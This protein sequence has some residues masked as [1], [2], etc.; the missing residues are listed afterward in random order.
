MTRCTIAAWMLLALAAAPLCAAPVISGG[1]YYLEPRQTGQPLQDLTIS[2]SGGDAVAGVEFFAQI[3]DGGAVNGGSNTKPT[4]TAI[5]LIGAGKVFVGGLGSNPQSPGPL[6]RWDDVTVPSTVPA[7]GTL[8]TVTIDTI[9]AAGGSYTLRLQNV[10]SSVYSGGLN[11]NFPYSPTPTINDG[12]IVILHTM[13]RDSGASGA[14]TAD[15]WTGGTWNNTPIYPDDSA[16]TVINSACTVNLDG[17]R[18]TYNL[19]I[20]NGGQLSIAAGNALTV[21]SSVADALTLGTNGTLTLAAG[22][23]LTAPGV[24]LSGGTL[25]AS[26]AYSLALPV[27]C[28]TGGTLSTALSGDSL[29]L[30]G[31]VTAAASNTLNKTGSGAVNLTG[32]I[33]HAGNIAVA[34]GLLKYNL[35]GGKSVTIGSGATLDIASGATVE[36]AGALSGTSAGGNRV[37][38]TNSSTTSGLLVS[39]AGQV[40]G[41][42]TG[43]GKTTIAAGGGLTADSLAQSALDIAAT[44]SLNVIG[45]VTMGSGGLL[46]MASGAGLTVGGN[47][48]LGNATLA[49]SGAYT[50]A[51]PLSTAGG[52]LS[53]AAGGDSLAL[54]GLLTAGASNTLSKTGSGTVTLSGGINQAGD[55]SIQGG[56]LKYNFTGGKPVTI[57]S[58]VSLNVAS[59]ATLELAGTQSGTNAGGNRVAVTNNS[60]AGGGLLV[61]GTNQVVGAVTGSGKTTIN[62]GADLTADSLAQGTLDIAA[63]GSLNVTGTLTVANG[64]TLTLVPTAGLTAGNVQLGNATLAISGGAYSLAS[65]LS[66]AGGTLSTALGTDSLTLSNSLTAPASNTL[67]KTGSGTANITGNINHAGIIAVD[68]GLLKYN[69]AAGKSATIGSAAALNIASGATVELA[70][71]LSGTSG[72]GNRLAVAN[73]ST[74]GGGL[75]VSGTNQVVGA[76][77]GTGKTTVNGSL[78]ADSIVQNTLEI[79][80]GGSVVIRETTSAAD[81]A[82]SVPEPGTLLL[83]LC[84]LLP[85]AGYARRKRFARRLPA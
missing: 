50:L 43:S 42:V 12:R 66:T 48:Q 30:S 35:P 59:G 21:V 68:G 78:T 33:N 38:V 14:W 10:Y 17:S 20:S 70:G 16:K 71:T 23:G 36:L 32:D 28:T 79:G 75:L 69:L 39:T 76:I 74:A 3:E 26:G 7:A 64:S 13:T 84:G 81:G 41:A 44:G 29:T 18:Q 37:A 60:T 31:L 67:S 62:A 52:T 5:D 25:A 72:G 19:N 65:P 56:L 1:T 45:D 9:G 57:G 83:V 34:G 4:I 63:T 15:A 53:T 11:T 51:S 61:S 55:I 58:G 85:L 24:Q 73:N 49:V 6:I 40:V 80:A 54:S 82:Q 22:A 8:A 2:V 46:T 27:N 47:V 77:T